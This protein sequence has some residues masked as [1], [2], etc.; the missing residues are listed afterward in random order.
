MIISSEKVDIEIFNP[1]ELIQHAKDEINEAIN[2]FFK[3]FKLKNIKI[4]ISFCSKNDIQR[5]NKKFR[6][7][8]QPTNVLSFPDKD[9]LNISKSVNSLPPPTT[10]RLQ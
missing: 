1:P 6:Q 9:I 8:N 2:K 4:D 5:L 7:K 3:I 10:V